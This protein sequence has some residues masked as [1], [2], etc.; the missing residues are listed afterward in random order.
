MQQAVRCG[1][2][3][4][5]ASRQPR[6]CGDDAVGDAAVELHECCR[7]AWLPERMLLDIHIVHRKVVRVVGGL[8]DSYLF[9][10]DVALLPKRPEVWVVS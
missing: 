1:E 6:E 5:G 8:C 3:I 4:V 10:N 9:L 7:G 2:I